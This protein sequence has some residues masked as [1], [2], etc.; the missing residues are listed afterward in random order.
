VS[1][2][3]VRTLAERFWS[4]VEIRGP[5]ECWPW[6]GAL[7]TRGYGHFR[8][9]ENG[10]G[11]VRAHRLALTLTLGPAPDDKPY[12]LHHCDNPA[13]CHVHPKHVQWGTQSENCEEMYR[14][15][16]RE[17]KRIELHGVQQDRV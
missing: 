13:C 15:F 4:H 8:V 11:V 10:T 5:D 16:R 6:K 17:P 1:R 9:D 2:W 7:N 12:G 3:P 14:R